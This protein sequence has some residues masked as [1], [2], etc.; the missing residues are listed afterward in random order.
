LE[1]IEW[2]SLENSPYIDDWCLDRL[3]GYFK[4][5]LTY[6]NINGCQNVTEKGIASLSRLRKLKNLHIG[7]HPRAQNL[8]LVCVM[9]EELLPELRIQGVVYCDQSL[10]DNSTSQ[11]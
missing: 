4:D 5:S 8:E 7:G 6:L 10:L 2:L 3:T 1:K 9:L 11:N